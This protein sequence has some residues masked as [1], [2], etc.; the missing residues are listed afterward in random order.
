MRHAIKVPA[1]VKT[2]FCSAVK[3]DSLFALAL[4]SC[5][6]LFK[7]ASPASTLFIFN[8]KKC[9]QGPVKLMHFRLKTRLLLDAFSPMA[10]A[11]KTIG[12]SGWW[13]GNFRKQF[14]VWTEETH[15]CKIVKADG[16]SDRVQCG[17]PRD[18]SRFNS[19]R[20]SSISVYF[21]LLQGYRPR[22]SH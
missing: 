19:G 6:W 3:I 7:I 16:V 21:I 20:F 22:D 8:N 1:L 5:N 15:Q 12:W 13:K 4:S 11:R 18:L 2:G 9:N 14:L 10:H 17:F